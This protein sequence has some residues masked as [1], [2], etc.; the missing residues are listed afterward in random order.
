MSARGVYPRLPLA[1]VLLLVCASLS[2]CAALSPLRRK[3]STGFLH[4]RWRRE[5]FSF[6]PLRVV[7]G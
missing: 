7:F 3:P 6:Y 4:P 1:F 5:S 2:A